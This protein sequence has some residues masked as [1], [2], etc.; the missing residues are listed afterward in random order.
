M[1]WWVAGWGGV[2]FAMRQS[3]GLLVCAEAP[4][5]AVLFGRRLDALSQRSLAIGDSGERGAGSSRASC[6][7]PL[8]R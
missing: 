7:I 4:E 3:D 2:P 5:A 1:A 8:G 6:L